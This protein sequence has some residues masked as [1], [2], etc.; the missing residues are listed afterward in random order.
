MKMTT[1]IKVKCLSRSVSM[2]PTMA[3]GLWPVGM[4]M[5]VKGEYMVT[6]CIVF[7]FLSICRSGYFRIRRGFLFWTDLGVAY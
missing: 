3:N 2:S 7:H 4:K 5:S 1:K 6:F